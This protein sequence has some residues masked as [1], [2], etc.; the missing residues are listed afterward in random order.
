MALQGIVVESI[1][2]KLASMQGFTFGV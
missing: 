1:R 2:R